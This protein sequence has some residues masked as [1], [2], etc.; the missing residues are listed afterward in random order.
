MSNFSTVS[1][2]CFTAF[3]SA[4]STAVKPKSKSR[5]D[6]VRIACHFHEVHQSLKILKEL[7]KLG[8]Q[9]A[10]NLMQISEQSDQKY[11]GRKISYSHTSRPL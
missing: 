6:M 2:A 5:V 4:S 9:V 7:K 3:N 8:Y 10:I 11:R 1:F